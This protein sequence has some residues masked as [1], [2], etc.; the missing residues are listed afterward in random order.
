MIANPV[1]N[2]LEND[3]TGRLIV[4]RV[5]VNSDAG[6]ELVNETGRRAT[7]T[8]IYFDALGNEQWRQFGSLDAEKVRASVP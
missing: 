1:V 3:L 7:P 2:G 6:R 5:S 4:I 8:F